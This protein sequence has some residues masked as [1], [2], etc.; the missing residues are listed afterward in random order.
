MLIIPPLPARRPRATAPPLTLPPAPPTLV[1]ASCDESPTLTLVFDRPVD[2]SA[3]D[4]GL[5]RVD[6]A[7]LGFTYVGFGEPTLL[8]PV[9][10]RLFMT[11][12]DD[13]TGPGIVL[14]AAA[15]NGIVA[16]DG[17]GPWAGVADV[18]LPFGE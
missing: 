16:A 8:D 11:G 5:I 7:L 3:I 13:Y 12:V 2:V 10:V 6:Y 15:G 18:E 9:T 4:V 1:A 14:S 17:G